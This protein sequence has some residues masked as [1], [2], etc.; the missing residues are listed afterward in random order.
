MC[1]AY[2]TKPFS[3]QSKGYTGTVLCRPLVRPGA[4]PCE[5]QPPLNT[6]SFQLPSASP[7]MEGIQ[8]NG[9]GGHRVSSS[10]GWAGSSTLHSLGQQPGRGL[11]LQLFGMIN[12]GLQRKVLV[13]T[14]MTVMGTVTK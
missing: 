9:E 6:S 1:R 8:W 14:S 5:D 2:L 10:S 12:H 13:G 11:H 4:V 3:G 7:S